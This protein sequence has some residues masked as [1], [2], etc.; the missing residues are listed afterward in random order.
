MA[1]PPEASSPPADELLN[2]GRLWRQNG[3]G[4]E[5]MHRQFDDQAR[6]IAVNIAKLPDL[7]RRERLTDL[8]NA[9]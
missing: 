4:N 6:R 8:P 3:D 7:L 2:S 9:S 1:R 5:E